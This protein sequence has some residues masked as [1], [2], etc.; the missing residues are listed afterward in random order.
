[1]LRSVLP[2]LRLWDP[3]ISELALCA[4]FH[5]EP[6]LEAPNLLDRRIDFVIMF[7][8]SEGASWRLL[9]GVSASR[10]AQR[11]PGIQHLKFSR[12]ECAMFARRAV[13]RGL[14]NGRM[15]RASGRH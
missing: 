7:I 13:H 10:V 4:P 15:C 5:L 2:P 3:N 12:A 9:S 1:M 14:W 11:D 6:T 8:K